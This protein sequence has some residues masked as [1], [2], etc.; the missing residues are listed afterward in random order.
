MEQIE[1][2]QL[3]LAKYLRNEIDFE[4]PNLDDLSINHL[5]FDCSDGRILFSLVKIENQLNLK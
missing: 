5:Y 2:H 3:I 1:K 4:Q